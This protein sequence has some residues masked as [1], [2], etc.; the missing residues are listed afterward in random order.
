[1]TVGSFQTGLTNL[2]PK[3]APGIASEAFVVWST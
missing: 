1:M 2:H 3:W